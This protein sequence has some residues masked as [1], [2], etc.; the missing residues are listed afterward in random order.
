NTG[1]VVLIGST[2][3]FNG[4]D[5]N[6]IDHCDV[7][8]IAGGNPIM[9]INGVG[10]TTSVQQYNDNNTISNCNIYDYFSPTVATAGIYLGT[11]TATWNITDN[12]F[13]QTAARTNTSSVSYRDLLI[14]NATGN[15]N[16]S[17]YIITGNYFGGNTSAG[18][19]TYTM[20]GTTTYAY[21]CMAISV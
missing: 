1:G 12:H 21:N 15:T 8:N 4:N 14:N 20:T 2:N 5:N 9:C 17:G 3:G 13:F 11:G 7:H 10:T 19:G 6:T 16:G 18:T